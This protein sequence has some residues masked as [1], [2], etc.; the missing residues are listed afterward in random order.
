[1]PAQKKGAI[2]S[3]DKK[4]QKTTKKESQTAQKRKPFP[5]YVIVLGLFLPLC[6]IWSGYSTSEVIDLNK[7]LDH[8]EEKVEDLQELV[9]YLEEE[10]DGLAKNTESLEVRMDAVYYSLSRYPE[11]TPKSTSPAVAKPSQDERWLGAEDARYVWLVYSDLQCPY[12]GLIHSELI[13]LAKDDNIAVVFRHLPYKTGSKNLA[14]AT[15]CV[16]KI[17]GEETFWRYI[18]DIYDAKVDL[19][20]QGLPEYV[21]KDQVQVCIDSSETVSKVNDDYLDAKKYG[22][23]STP[24]NVIYDMK[25]EKTVL[26]EGFMSYSKMITNLESFKK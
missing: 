12:C 14:V 25:T 5:V 23:S 26:I 8:S 11:L 9:A 22:F 4:S 24:T 17:D 10:I 21:S 19:D 2:R 6:V 3:E 15:E 1:M 18:Q 13:K 16:A 7:E 20:L